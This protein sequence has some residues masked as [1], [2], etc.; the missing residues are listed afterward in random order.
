MTIG[1]YHAGS[2]GWEP[3]VERGMFQMFGLLYVHATET[4]MQPACYHGQRKFVFNC[5]F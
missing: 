2:D 5:R 3:D 1:S 4:G